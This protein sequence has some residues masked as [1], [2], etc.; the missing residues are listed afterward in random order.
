MFGS[1]HDPFAEQVSGWVLPHHKA[2][3]RRIAKQKGWS[4][5]KTVR[6][7]I[8]SALQRNLGEQY[9]VM[10]RTTI[11]DAMKKEVQKYSNGLGR[12]PR[13]ECRGFSALLV[14]SNGTDM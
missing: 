5:S 8:D 3:V 11:E 2:E 12:P 1:S 13:H 7:L 9:A 6:T 4:E 14:S 10:L